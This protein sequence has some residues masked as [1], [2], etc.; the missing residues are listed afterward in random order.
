MQLGYITFASAFPLFNTPVLAGAVQSPTVDPDDL[1]LA[2]ESEF[3]GFAD[4]VESMPL[5]QFESQRLSLF[6]RVMN[7]PSTQAELSNAIWGAIGL[8]RP[9]N[10]RM[11]QAQ[12]LE[13]LTKNQF[14]AYL[15]KRIQDPIILKAYRKDGS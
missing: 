1:A 4:T 7:P 6:N 2:I 12:T 11:M 9:F 8:R 3:R 13:A 14:I 10:D 5:E 15:K